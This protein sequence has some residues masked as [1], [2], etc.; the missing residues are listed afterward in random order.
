MWQNFILDCMICGWKKPNVEN[1]CSKSLYSFFYL[2]NQFEWRKLKC[3][4][5][6]LKGGLAEKTALEISSSSDFLKPRKC[7]KKS[8]DTFYCFFKEYLILERK[9]DLKNCLALKGWREH[10]FNNIYS[11]FIILIYLFISTRNPTSVS[12]SCFSLILLKQNYSDFYWL[13]SLFA[14]QLFWVNFDHF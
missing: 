11:I 1:L 12:S 6:S 7:E 14:S 3:I 13:R 9:F 2:L 8:N 4:W 10:F 5:K